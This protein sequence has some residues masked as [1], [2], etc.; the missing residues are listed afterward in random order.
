MNLKIIKNMD[1]IIESREII[2]CSADDRYILV[3]KAQG[4]IIGLNFMQG[5]EI[6]ELDYFRK[7]YASID[8]EL[9]NFYN[10]IHQSLSGSTEI[11]RINQAMWGYVNFSNPC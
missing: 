8:Y 10:A 4:L 11:D 3:V 2:R 7:E 6:G 9:T 1:T 5:C